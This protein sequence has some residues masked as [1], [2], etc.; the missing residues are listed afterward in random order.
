MNQIC[1]ALIV[2]D[3]EDLRDILELM[4]S[5]MGV[6]VVSASNGKEAL[7]QLKEKKIDLVISD[8]SMPVMDGVTLLKELRNNTD[9]SQP[10][11]LFISGGIEFD[12]TKQAL[13]NSQSDGMIS[14]PFQADQILDNLFRIFPG[15]NF[16][17]ILKT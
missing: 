10:H 14:K 17:K 5:R 9:L 2:D 12:E 1:R 4:L 13:I 7:I 3:E 11:F 16:K 8:I 15:K 6:D